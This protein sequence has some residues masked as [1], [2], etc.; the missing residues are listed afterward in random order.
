VGVAGQDDAEPQMIHEDAGHEKK[1]V[2]RRAQTLTNFRQELL[3]QC[4][5]NKSRTPGHVIFSPEIVVAELQQY[6]QDIA[7]IEVE[8]SKINPADF[9]GNFID[10]NSLVPSQRR[11]CTTLRCWTRT[12]RPVSRSL[13]RVGLRT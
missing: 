6:M 2:E 10:S 12:A 9:P 3:G 1:K 11:K 4:S 13:S 7:D 5:N 8:A